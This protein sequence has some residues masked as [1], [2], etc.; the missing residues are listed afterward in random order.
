MADVVA[1][2]ESI[3]ISF[4]SLKMLT[5]DASDIFTYVDT[6]DGEILRSYC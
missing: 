5:N 2:T 4:V 3:S 1:K 6:D